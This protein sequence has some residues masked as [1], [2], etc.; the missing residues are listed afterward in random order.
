MQP[1]EAATL[2][3]SVQGTTYM[4][5]YFAKGR[6]HWRVDSRAFSGDL[7]TRENSNFLVTLGLPLIAVA[8]KSGLEGAGGPPCI[9]QAK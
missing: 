3:I 5:Q 4:P 9:Q 7:A 1:V 2:G 8:C 6:S